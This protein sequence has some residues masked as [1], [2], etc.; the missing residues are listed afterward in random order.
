MI[1][2]LQLYLQQFQKWIGVV[3]KNKYVVVESYRNEE[4]LFNLE[5]WALTAESFFLQKNG[6]GCLTNLDIQEI[7]SLFI[8]SSYIFP[9]HL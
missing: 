3:G 1:R 6:F 5:C 8:L 7:M 2:F 9:M 4:E